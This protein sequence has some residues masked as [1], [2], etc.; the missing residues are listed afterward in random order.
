MTRKKQHAFYFDNEE[1]EELLEEIPKGM[2]SILIEAV[3]VK[4]LP[5]VLNNIPLKYASEKKLKDYLMENLEINLK[6]EKPKRKQKKEAKKEGVEEQIEEQ[7]EVKEKPVVD[8]EELIRELEEEERMR[9]EELY[10]ECWENLDKV[11]KKTHTY[12]PPKYLFP[13]R[14]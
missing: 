13:W 11:E 8:E 1:L 9:L 5:E 10:N 12:R 3:L 14:E 4:A 2:K 7:P 6:T